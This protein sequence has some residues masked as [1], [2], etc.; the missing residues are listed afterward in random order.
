[1][2][3][4]N[5]SARQLLDNSLID[6]LAAV[7]A[8]TALPSG[9]LWLE[10]T[11]TAL[12]EDLDQAIDVLERIRDLGARIAI[13]DFGTGW[14]SLTYLREFPVHALKI[15]RIFVAGLGTGSRDDAIVASMISLGHELDVV[16]IAEGVER[17]DQRRSLIDLGCIVGQG[18]LFGRPQPASAIDRLLHDSMLGH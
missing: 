13:D 3:A 17:E 15:D 10:V 18:Y 5:L 6:R 8:A 11:E 2:P 7:M 14:A 16:V 4:V 1:V 9:K 12:V